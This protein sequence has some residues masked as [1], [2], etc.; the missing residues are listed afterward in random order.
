MDQHFELVN[1][2]YLDINE[3][4]EIQFC[5]VRDKHTGILYIA[6]RIGTSGG[7]TPLLDEDGK[8]MRSI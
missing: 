3:K 2:E 5:I 8:P 7:I 1:S 6:E 4:Q